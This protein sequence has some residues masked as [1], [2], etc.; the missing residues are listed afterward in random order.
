MSDAQT[1]I[2]ELRAMREEMEEGATWFK[3]QND[4]MQSELISRGST[5]WDQDI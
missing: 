2:D 5:P 3:D 4:R 1:L